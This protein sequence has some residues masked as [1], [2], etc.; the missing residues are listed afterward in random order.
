MSMHVVVGPC[1]LYAIQLR[2]AVQ[3]AT[4]ER[5]I[6]LP[7]QQQERQDHVPVS[8]SESTRIPT[9][10]AKYCQTIDSRVDQVTLHKERA[11]HLDIHGGLHSL[12]AA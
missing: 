1:M 4:K 5:A 2:R 3:R 6:V 7:L 12:R 9:F 8:T 10:T 11:Q